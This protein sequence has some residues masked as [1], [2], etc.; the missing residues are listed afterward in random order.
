MAHIHNY[1]IP[2]TPKPQNPKTPK[3]LRIEVLS[4]MSDTI[5]IQPLVV[6]SIG[7]HY[8]RYRYIHQDTKVSVI[9]VLLGKKEADET[10]VFNC[11]ETKA[12]LGE[13]TLD[14]EFT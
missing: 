14:R 5:V 12:D 2:K 6:M 4:K 10:I 7:D 3:P 11:F 1:T 13:G 8:T 9:G